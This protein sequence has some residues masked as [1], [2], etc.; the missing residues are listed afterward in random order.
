MLFT[1]IPPDQRGSHP[2]SAPQSDASDL[3]IQVD[4][5]TTL[6]PT[7]ACRVPIDTCGATEASGS[8]DLPDHPGRGPIGAER[9][10]NVALAAPPLCY[11]ECCARRRTSAAGDI[12]ATNARTSTST[13]CCHNPA[14]LCSRSEVR[15]WAIAHHR[16]T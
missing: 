12:S 7:K 3:V 15:P 11:R 4:P 10:V 8:T 16:T 1:T 9:G 13:S 5:R 14:G 2:H 6:W